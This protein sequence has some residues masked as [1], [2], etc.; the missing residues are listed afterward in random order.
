MTVPRP[1]RDRPG[2]CK[3]R[4]DGPLGVAGFCLLFAA[5]ASVTAV[6]TLPAAAQPPTADEYRLKA[7]VLY[8]F[9]KFVDPLRPTEDTR[10][11]RRLCVVGADPFGSTLDRALEGKEVD[12]RPLSVHRYRDGGSAVDCDLVF[13]SFVEEQGYVESLRALAGRP[14]LIVHEDR[15]FT[16]E[17]GTINLVV[18]D[19]KVAFEVNLEA[20]RRSGL[21]ISSRLLQLASRVEGRRSQ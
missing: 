4:R 17:G 12:G 16:P 9:L 21:R 14:I 20:A 10:V 13:L 6:T 19:G 2:A 18:A 8:N 15:D 1:G 11:E 7:A 5:V 3:E